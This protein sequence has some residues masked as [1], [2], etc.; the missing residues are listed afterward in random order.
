LSFQRRPRASVSRH[1]AKIL[2]EQGWNTVALILLLVAAVCLVIFAHTEAAFFAA[3]LGIVSWFMG[4][5]NRF[6]AASIETENQTQIEGESS[7]K[8]DE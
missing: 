8:S 4:L 5:R 6:Y 3:T 1:I 2:S 7:D